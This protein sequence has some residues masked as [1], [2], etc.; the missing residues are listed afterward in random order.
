[1]PSTGFTNAER[2]AKRGVVSTGNSSTAT[3][4]GDAVF[5]GTAEIVTGY[6]GIAILAYSDVAS[7]DGGLLF[8]SS[9]DGTNWDSSLPVTLEANKREIHTLA[10]ISKYFRVVYTNGSSAQ[11]EFRLEVMYTSG[12]G[13]LTSRAQQQITDDYDVQLVR[14]VSDYGTDVGAGLNTD[15]SVVNKFGLAFSLTTSYTP[16]SIG[17]VY[18]T[19]QVASATTLRIKSGGNANDT[20]AGSGARE[21]TLE[22]V[23]ETGA[24]V[25]EALATAG[26]SASSATTAT[27]LRLF[28][29]Y[30]SSSG[31]YASAAAGSHSAAITIENGSG[32]TDWA[33]IDATSFPK[34]QSQIGV[35]TVPLGKVG[36]LR[37]YH[38]NVTTSGAKTVDFIMF[39][40]QNIL[41]TSAPY[42]GMR[43]IHELIGVG[44]TVDFEYKIPVKLPAL[45][46]FGFMAKGASTPDASVEF[47]IE[48]V[49]E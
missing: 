42:S 29:A 26:A 3:L 31:T 47:T 35:Y 33:T 12:D 38:L 23:D 17:R 16:V 6:G 14:V 46:D 1:M 13:K 40:R 21:V 19:P 11:S 7:A 44:D 27:F 15:R 24:F 43:A 5:T 25:T 28:R 22:G 48:L 4:A 8:Q 9:Q 10:V 41:E 34:G 36:Y 18:Q 20:A 32:G 37:E 30:V 2:G 45:T 39:Q 49:D